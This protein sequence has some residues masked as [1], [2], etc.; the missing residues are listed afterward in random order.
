[1]R[2]HGIVLNEDSCLLIL[3]EGIKPPTQA[4][5]V[6]NWAEQMALWLESLGKMLRADPAIAVVGLRR[7]PR[8]VEEEGNVHFV[9]DVTFPSG[10]DS[11]LDVILKGSKVMLPR[12][13]IHVVFGS[14]PSS[15]SE[16]IKR[17]LN[18]LLVGQRLALDAQ[19]LSVLAPPAGASF[20][21]AVEQAGQVA[22]LVNASL[23]GNEEKIMAIAGARTSDKDHRRRGKPSQKPSKMEFHADGDD[24]G[25]NEQ[26]EDQKI[27]NEVQNVSVKIKDLCCRAEEVLREVEK[28]AAK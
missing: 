19:S 21:D 5:P 24:V 3:A 10:V 25:T 15:E 12:L 16:S 26:D 6:G 14:C 8:E 22:K 18:H 17:Q 9:A 7:L 1:M 27:L 28:Y 20:C 2:N 4:D 13:P 11:L 23:I